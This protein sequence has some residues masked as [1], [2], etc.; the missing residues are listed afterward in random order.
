M[1]DDIVKAIQKATG[2]KEV[3]LEAPEIQ[4]HGDFSSNVA[5]HAA[6]KAP[7]ERAERIVAK[8]KKDKELMKLVAK[9]E[10]AGPGFI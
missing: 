6:S 2:V 4:S 10:V 5:L 8:L 3:N 1:K 9:I 7:R